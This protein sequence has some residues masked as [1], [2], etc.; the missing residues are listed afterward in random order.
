[1][2]RA[3][4]KE[5]GPRLRIVM[6]LDLPRQ[7][8]GRLV[9]TAAKI[10]QRQ[11]GTPNLGDAWWCG[12][13]T[14]PQLYIQSDSKWIVTASRDQTARVWDSETGAPLTPWF[15]HLDELS[16]PDLCGTKAK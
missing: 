16:E 3:N 15:R 13:G 9:A 14:S 7:S 1:L 6:V 4:G 8:D 5:S 12:M 11:S 2:G 10:H